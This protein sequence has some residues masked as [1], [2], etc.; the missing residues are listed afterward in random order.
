MDTGSASDHVC[1]FSPGFTWEDWRARGTLRERVA[2]R[3]ASCAACGRKRPTR[4]PRAP[5]LLEAEAA[6][7]EAAPW[8][9]PVGRR[10][11][12][13]LIRRA[14]DGSAQGVPVRGLIGTSLARGI[15]ASRVEGW[16]EAFL[17]C[18][19]VRLRWRLSGGRRTLAVVTTLNLDAL[20]EFAR[21][22]ERQERQDALAD[23]R[24]AVATLVHPVAGEVARLLHTD[25][26]ETLAPALIRALAA[27]V[28]HAE[29]GEVLAARVFAAR[30]L[31]SSKALERWRTRLEER[32]GP[33]EALGIRD[34][35]A[36]TL[37]GGS[38]RVCLAACE[39][40]LAAVAPFLGLAN[41]ALGALEDVAFPP[42]GLLVGE[43]FAPF[44]ACC[45]GEVEPFQ[46]ALVVWSQGYPGR[47]V[48]RLVE[49][50]AAKGAPVRVWADVD[51]DGVRIVRL[52]AS[53]APAAVQAVRMSPSDL[54]AAPTSQPLPER[55]SAAIRADLKERPDALL[56]DTLR[57]L[58]ED[59]RWVEQEAFLG[60]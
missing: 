13:E 3:E 25:E 44:E 23:A 26:A 52:V 24:A 59:G 4:R 50:A 9:D 22:G 12:A 27:V 18:G 28:R 20:R 21:P 39:I 31:G 14:R 35:A 16:L 32:L 7:C 46:G 33:L 11:A 17:R 5:A 43:N 37:L 57:A 15:P 45:R 53:W 51:L 34:G 55:A 56:A 54:A 1:R 10:V 58:L 30:Y 47:A 49:L 38:G 41:E 48:R 42:A 8:P 40:D 6:R 19:W 29:A 60:R 2:R 36:V